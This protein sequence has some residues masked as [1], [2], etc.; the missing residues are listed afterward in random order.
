LRENLP[1]VCTFATFNPFANFL[2]PAVRAATG[3]KQFGVSPK[4]PSLTVE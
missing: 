1:V 4:R 3:N 2:R